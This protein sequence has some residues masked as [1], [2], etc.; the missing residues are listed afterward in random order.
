[1]FLVIN[2]KADRIFIT[3][4]ERDKIALRREIG[5]RMRRFLPVGSG[6][7][8]NVLINHAMTIPAYQG[9]LRVRARFTAGCVSITSALTIA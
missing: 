1:V 5:Y 3:R 2:P 4:R 7:Q 9:L 6:W 8:V